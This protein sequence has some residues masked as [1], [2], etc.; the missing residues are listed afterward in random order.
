M[1]AWN[2]SVI[3]FNISRMTG[4]FGL[5]TLV[6]WLA[7]FPLYMVGPAPSVYDGAAYAEYRG[8]HM[9]AFTRILLDQGVYV[10]MMIFAAGFRRLV[11]NERAEY[12]WLG[13]LLFGAAVVWLGVTLIADGLA[14]GATLDAISDAPDPSVIRA[15]ILGTLLIY[16][17][18]TA[19]VMTAFFLAVAGCATHVTRFLPRWTAWLAFTGAALCL[20]FIP[21]MYAGAVDYA[22]FYNVGGFAPALA[23]NFLPALWFAAVSL[24]LLRRKAG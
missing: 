19:F 8:I 21:T 9:I 24:Y 4:A 23:A 2:L 11:H 15:L 10:S 17:G 7:Q 14:A 16:N 22:R 3:G 5:A 1:H 18:S 6:F 20:A 12:E 13:T